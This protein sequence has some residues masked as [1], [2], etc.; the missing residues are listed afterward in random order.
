MPHRRGLSLSQQWLLIAVVTLVPMLALVAYASWSFYQQMHTQRVL[1]D[2]SDALASRQSALNAEVRDLERFARQYR[3]LRDAAFLEPYQQKRESILNELDLLTQ[4]LRDGTSGRTELVAKPQ[5]GGVYEAIVSLEN[6]LRTLSDEAVESWRD[7]DF[8]EQLA[9]LSQRRSALDDSVNAYVEVLSDRSEMALQQI[10]WRL[11]LLGMISL[12]VT[13]TLM[14]LGFWQ[15]IRPLRR[16]SSAIRNLGHRD[17]E[18]PIRVAGPRDL[19]ALGERLEWLRG[20]LLT[21][22]QQKQIFLRHVSHELKTPLSAIVEAGSLLQDEVPGPINARQ[23]NVLRI[24]LENSQ[25]LQEL[26]QQLLNYNVITH[27]VTVE[28]RAVAME[29]LCARITKRLDQQNLRHRVSW[30]CQGTPGSLKGDIHLLEMILTNLLSNAYHYSSDGGVVR[31]RWGID[32]NGA[33]LSV[34]DQGP[35]IQP[36]DQDKIF[37]PFVQGRVRRHGSVHGS[38][39][40]LAIVKESVARL[41]G[42]IELTSTPGE[43]SCFLLRYPV[44][45]MRPIEPSNEASTS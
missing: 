17:W 18:T 3:L 21:A 44:S 9:V 20:Q 23:Q 33:W 45:A 35:G 5:Q 8:T 41:G 43:G 12:P 29:P 27:N 40:G 26:I 7:E 30:D 37:Q 24:L 39:V 34:A 11:S 10:L 32:Q 38:G 15:M 25:N 6:T 16:L 22:E 14:A 1:V 4:W 13:L 42:T 19:Q 2:H 28:D 36:E 31:V